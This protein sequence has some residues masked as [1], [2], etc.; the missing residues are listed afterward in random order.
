MLCAVVRARVQG[1]A[2][3]TGGRAA[4]GVEH[5]G[6]HQRQ[7][8]PTHTRRMRQLHAHEEGGERGWVGVILAGGLEGEVVQGYGA[9]GAGWRN[10]ARNWW[11]RCPLLGVRTACTARCLFHSPRVLHNACTAHC[12]YR[13]LLM[14]RDAGTKQRIDT[15]LTSIPAVAHSQWVPLAST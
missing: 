15:W 7:V 1:S 9:A 14:M 13:A 8:G 11:H 5:V 6:L 2:A 12:M 3:V 4:V 10:A